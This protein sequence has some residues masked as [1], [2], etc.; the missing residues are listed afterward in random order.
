ME[1]KGLIFIPDISGFTE[2]ITNIE[3]DHSRQ[4]IQQLIELLIDENH[5]GLEVSEIEGDAVLFYKFG[6]SPDLSLIYEQVEK[7]FSSFHNHLEAYEK[8]RTCNCDACSSA[9]N[10]TLKFITHYGEFTINKIKEFKT[11]I[12]KDVIIAHQL[13]KNAID[14][15]EYWLVTKNL[16]ND[17]LPV[18][19]REWMD[20]KESKKEVAGNDVPFVYTHLTPLRKN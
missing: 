7:M 6:D 12:G 10:L 11:L 15:N 3:L 4:I 5:I 19:F 20:W 16:S 2:F 14:K 13:L 1:N 9:I 18:G 17:M 8:N